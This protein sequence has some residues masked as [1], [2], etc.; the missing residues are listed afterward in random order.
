MFP[1]LLIDNFKS[2]TA[3]IPVYIPLDLLIH[4]ILCQNA[5]FLLYYNLKHL[6]NVAYLVTDI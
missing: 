4:A 6:Y 2:K 1:Y 5:V 3:Q